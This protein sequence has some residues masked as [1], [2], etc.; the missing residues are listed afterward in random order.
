MDRVFQIERFDELRQIIGVGVHVVAVPRL[1]RSPVAAAVMSDAA[2]TAGCQI[3]HLVL[4]GIR[5]QRPAVTENHRLPAAPVFVV[6]LDV[7][8]IF[9]TDCNVRHRYSPFVGMNVNF[10]RIRQNGAT[11]VPLQFRDAKFRK[12]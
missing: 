8:G 9:F 3:K 11:H 5:T 6:N 10:V 1:A 2:I 12:M 4:K 7:G